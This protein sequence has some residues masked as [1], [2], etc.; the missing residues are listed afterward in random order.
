MKI[1]FIGT[2]NMGGALA[3]AAARENTNELLL[4]NRH[5]EKARRLQ[6]F[7]YA[8][9]DRENRWYMPGF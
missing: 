8:W 1:A 9:P 5:Q 4:F 3:R 6:V 7:R 2:G